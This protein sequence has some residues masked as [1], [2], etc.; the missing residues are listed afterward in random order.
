M[1]LRFFYTVLFVLTLSTVHAADMGIGIST[2]YAGWD[3]KRNDAKVKMDEVLYIGP[4]ISYQF[5]EKW[6]CTLVALA[7]PQKYTW[8]V[9]TEEMELRRYD[10]DLAL[11]YQI[12]RYTK[13]FAGAKY[14]AFA[15]HN[16]TNGNDG[17]HHATGP[18]AGISFTMP[19]FTNVYVLANLS[20]L[21]ILGNQ[22][23]D[24]QTGTKSINF[25]EIGANGS[26]Q[27]AYYFPS[28]AITLAAGYRLQYVETHYLEKEPNNPNLD[29]T[30]KGF[31]VL[32]V[33]SFNL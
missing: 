31:T 7:T 21:Y 17:L 3:V 26:L 20:G 18:G 27:L 4:S 29:H 22:K 23:E 11:N 2:W 9:G 33:K 28:V 16:K 32:L 13:V 15:Y 19:V 5:H 10:V 8:Q 6:S 1:K 14:L 25:Y 12:N 30:F 24:Q